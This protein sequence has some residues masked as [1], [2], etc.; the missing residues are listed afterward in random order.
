MQRQKPGAAPHVA[1]YR[2]RMTRP[3]ILPFDENHLTDAGRLLA[4]RHRRHRLAQP[5]LPKR[6]EDPDVARAE[7]D[8][9]WSSE[10]AS[11]AVAVVGGRAV[12]YLLGAPKSLGVWGPNVWVDSAGHAAESAETLR[13][14]Y[15]LAAA[16]WADEGRTAHYVLVP[17]SDADALRSWFRLAFGQQHSHGLRGTRLGPPP[18]PPRVTV[19]R[20]V[21]DDIPTLARLDL[22]LPRHQALSPTFSS[23]ELGSYEESLHEWEEDFDDPEFA[24]FV[25]KYDGRVVGSAVGCPLEKSSINTGL[26]RPDGAG[27]LGFAAVFP[28][29]RG[30]GAGRALGE[31]VLAWSGEQQHSCVVTDWRTTN[32]LSSR[33]WPALGF[34]E[35]FVRLHRH[36]GF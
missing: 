4:E 10:D 33:A 6:F 5:L 18:P 25:A 22:E 1:A 34:E 29:D 7:V 24:T 13:D 36:L 26:A 15:G 19:R 21:R 2:A 27:F 30:L 31:A 17:A 32:L 20:A 3:E 16:R 11:G 9:L 28:E 8:S 14:L 35:S 12:G 23:G